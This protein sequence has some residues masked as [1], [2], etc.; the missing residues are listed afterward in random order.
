MSYAHRPAGRGYA[1][2]HERGSPST[3]DAGLIRNEVRSGAAW[4]LHKPWISATPVR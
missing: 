2:A 4:S 1:N 3:A